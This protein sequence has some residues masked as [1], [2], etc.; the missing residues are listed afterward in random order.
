M[1][2]NANPNLDAVLARVETAGGKIVVPRTALP[3]G[4]GFWA[5]IQDTEGNLV[6][7]HAIS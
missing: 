1:Y 4:M 2:L 5:R 3:A 6:G 7:L